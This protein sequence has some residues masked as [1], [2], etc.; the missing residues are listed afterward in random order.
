MESYAAALT[1]CCGLSI[2]CG[3]AAFV[4]SCP[5]VKANG[6]IVTSPTTEQT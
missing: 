4:V 5:S 1:V 2:I 6:E 3:A